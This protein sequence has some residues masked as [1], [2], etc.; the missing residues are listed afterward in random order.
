MKL[1]IRPH[2]IGTDTTAEELGRKIHEKGFYG[3][4]LAIAK[5][6]KGQSGSP[7]TLTA[8]VVKNISKGFNENGVEI[9]I[10]GAYFNPVHSDKKKVAD[11]QVKFADHLRKAKDF[12]AIYVASETGSYND[13][14]WTYNPKNQTD[15]AFEEDVKIFGP[16]A[17]VARDA[18]SFMSIEGAWHHCTYCP[19]QMNRLI[20]EIDTGYVRT[21][22]DILNYLYIGNYEKRYDIFHECLDLF[23]DKIGIFHIK[24]FIPDGDHLTEVG[25]GKGIMGWD[26]I[27]PEIKANVPNA[28]LVFEGVKDLD[29]SIAYF[30]KLIEQ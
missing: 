30:N 11:G 26:K 18:K 23:A 10:L 20:K 1:C 19:K 21:T 6:I 2:D 4:Q 13:D 3:V 7:E 5:A 27:I 9:P 28:F 17:E 14:Q 12:G 24:D 22:V 25:L 29:E 16:L 8:D 15:E